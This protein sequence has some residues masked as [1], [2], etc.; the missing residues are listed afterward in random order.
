MLVNA[1]P[2]LVVGLALTVSAWFLP[3][4]RPGRW[5][6][7]AASCLLAGLTRLDGLDRRGHGDLAAGAVLA[8]AVTS[9][10]ARPT[11]DC[12]RAAAEP[13]REDQPG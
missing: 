2:H 5:T 8:V 1:L 6:G 12:A 9:L 10:L 4:R 3:Q 13:R 7:L 11:L